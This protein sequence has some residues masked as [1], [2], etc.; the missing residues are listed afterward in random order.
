ML[1]D[2]LLRYAEIMKALPE[3]ILYFRDRVV[4]DRF[5]LIKSEETLKITHGFQQALDQIKSGPQSNK[6]KL[7]TLDSAPKINIIALS[8]GEKTRFFPNGGAVGQ[9][10]KKNLKG[11]IIVDTTD[12][13]KPGKREQTLDFHLQSHSNHCEDEKQCGFISNTHYFVLKNESE[14][15]G[16][17]IKRLVSSLSISRMT[18]LLL[19]TSA[20]Q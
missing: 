2:L 6:K 12:F 8:D 18:G 16:E 10:T 14:W 9:E 17:D 19:T 11:G 13:Q 20:D 4:D 7:K 1:K 5:D 3:S 15:T